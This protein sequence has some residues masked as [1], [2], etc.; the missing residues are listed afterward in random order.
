MC[1][2][3]VAVPSPGGRS[4]ARVLRTGGG[5]LAVDLGERGRRPPRSSTAS[6]IPP[7]PPPWAASRRWPSTRRPHPSPARRRAA[8]RTPASPRAGAHLGG[9]RGRRRPAGRRQPG[10]R[11][12]A[13]RP[14]AERP[15]RARQALIN[16]LR[17]SSRPTSSATSFREPAAWPQSARRPD[18]GHRPGH[19]PSATEP[20]SSPPR[21]PARAVPPPWVRPWR[22][23]ASSLGHPHQ[24]SVRGP[25]HHPAGPLRP[26]RHGRAAVPGLLAA[27]PGCLRR[28][29]GGHA[30]R[31]DTISLAGLSVGPDDG[32]RLRE[33]GLLPRLLGALVPA[34]ADGPGGGHHLLHPRPHAAAVALGSPRARRAAR[35]RSSICAS[36][37]APCWSM[38]S[39]HPTTWRRHLPP[40]PLPGP[41]ATSATTDETW[42]YGDRNQYMKLATLLTHL[43]LILF[44]LGGAV[45]VAFG[46]ETV[47]FVGDGQT[48]PV[49]PVG[50]T[51][52]P[53]GRRS[54]ASRRRSAP[55]ARSPTT[56]PTS[57]STRTVSRSRA[58]PSASTT[59]SR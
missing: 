11:S 6:A 46:F 13:P 39:W 59:R 29:A 27:R 40:T 17:A 23:W 7:G 49:Q 26:G 38:P 8:S 24:R 34:A 54:S 44:L 14:L 47:V 12:G 18:V 56:A 28:P 36:P 15:R 31:W 5:M 9:P 1:L 37:S 45:T 30:R 25:A 53:A 41:P 16:R 21:P 42:V 22:A 35:C 48:A 57:R 51:R 50:H 58:R 20:A 2:P 33:A 43:G 32:R 19:T 10:A 4:H 3:G 55:T 52:Q